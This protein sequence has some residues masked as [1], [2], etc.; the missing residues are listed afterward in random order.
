MF[1]SR[2]V[3]LRVTDGRKYC[4]YSGYAWSSTAIMGSLGI[5]AHLYLDT[6]TSKR[7]SMIED[8]ETIGWLGVSVIF[9]PIAFIVLLNV[10]FYV[11]T[12]K[13][14][15]RMNTY[16]RIHHKLKSS[17]TMFSWIFLV[18]TIAWLFLILSWLRMDGLLYAHIVVN[19]LQAP[20][21][22]YFCV[23][24][25][26]HVTFLLKKSCCYNEPPAA[27]DWGDEL[28]YMNTADY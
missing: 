25:Q 9:T 8:Q 5:F 2:N 18:M 4:W 24:R 22:L 13:I 23:L 11:S 12:L 6:N 20:L 27:A 19:A 14:L 17:F 1:R 10:F 15:N 21:M 3:F 16:G 7:N 28:T 26:K